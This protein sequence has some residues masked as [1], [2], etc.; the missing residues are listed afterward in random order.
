MPASS[1]PPATWRLS[2]AHMRRCCGP[3]DTRAARGPTRGARCCRF[4]RRRSRC[5]RCSCTGI[6][7]RRRPPGVATAVDRRRHRSPRS[8]ARIAM[9]G[10]DFTDVEGAAIRAFHD[11]E[12]E[13]E[14][15]RAAAPIGGAS[16]VWTWIESNHRHNRLLWDEEDRARRRD[17]ADAAIAANKRAIDGYNQRRNDAIE[18]IDEALLERL[19][20]RRPGNGCVAQLGVRRLDRRSAFDPVAQDFPHACRDDAR[21]RD[22]SPSGGLSR[23][24]RPPRRSSAPICRAASTRC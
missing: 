5:S 22:G 23:K 10:I 2:R 11:A 1:A 12:L 20:R 3:G 8:L 6:F 4:R 19:A 17:V 15:G 7:S 18:R 24:A 21:R 14:V 9:T 16:G 13:R